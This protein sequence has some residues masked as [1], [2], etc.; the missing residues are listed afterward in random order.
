MSVNLVPSQLTL[1]AG[2][3]VGNTFQILQ[4]SDDA[5]VSVTAAGNVQFAPQINCSSASGIVASA[6]DVKSFDAGNSTVNSLNTL[7]RSVN[8]QA[9]SLAN[10]ISVIN[11]AFGLNLS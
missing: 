10:V 4:N 6:G 7:A 11:T 9:A 3:G 2:S 5:N 8:G 1:T